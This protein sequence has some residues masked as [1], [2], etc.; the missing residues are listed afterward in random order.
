MELKAQIN[1]L[2]VRIDQNWFNLKRMVLDISNAKYE[3]ILTF[4]LIASRFEEVHSPL[5]NIAETFQE[6]LGIPKIIQ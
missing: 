3:F 1:I 5:P 4:P 2:A 6:I